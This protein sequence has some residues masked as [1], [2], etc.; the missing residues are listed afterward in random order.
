MD[1]CQYCQELEW[2]LSPGHSGEFLD[3][4]CLGFFKGD[5]FFIIFSLSFEKQL[6][7]VLSI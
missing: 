7:L 1:A 3:Q 5:F 2:F 6:Q 4:S